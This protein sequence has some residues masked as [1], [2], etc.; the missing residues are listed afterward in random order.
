MA[1]HSPDAASRPPAVSLRG[2]AKRFGP[3]VAVDGV[4]LDVPAG[5][6]HAL[7]GENGAGKTSLMNVLAGLYRP[8]QGEILIHGRPV[9]IHSPDDARRLGIGMVH[10]EQRL[11]GRFSAPENVSLGHP[12]EPG[13]LA[14]GGYFR[15]LARR[16][17]RRYQLPIDAH[18]PVWDLPL[19]RRQRVELVKL[20]HHG[21]EI[22]ILDEPSGNLAP[23]EVEVFFDSVRQLVA[24]GRTVILITHKLEEVLRYADWVTVMR[25]G[26]VVANLPP[27]LVGRDELVRL[28]VGEE[29][30]ALVRAEAPPPPQTVGPARLEI[31]GLRAGDPRERGALVDV[32]LRVRGGEL[33]AIA[34]V[35]GNGQTRLAEAVTGEL[36]DY[37]GR[38]ALDGQDLRGL[39]ARQV[40]R[41]GVAYLPE[42]RQEVGL[43]PSASV[44]LN[45]VLRRYDQPPFS[46]G[47]WLDQRAIRAEADRLIER[48]AIRTPS[49]DTPVGQLSGGNQQRV[50][51]ARELSGQPRLIVADNV[52]RGLDPLSAQQLKGELLAHRARGAAA[53]WITGDLSEALECD[54]VAVLRGGRL[55][56]LLERGEASRES[57]GRLMTDQEAGER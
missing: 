48:Y 11:V 46:R 31:E 42:N 47:G 33:V 45:L 25:A 37:Q 15:S 54:R 8:D 39:D 53:L 36:A 12:R 6:V 34:G 5:E 27:A 28:M 17:S 40:A 20:L 50:I 1:R 55:V 9:E 52:T 18:A 35:A 32:N 49:P 57:V 44:A 14:T 13:F 3:V 16:L 10:Q 2:I 4:D 21:A 30:P 51:I 22:L 43:I 56:G 23:A 38:V 41:L 29:L 26:R 7:L 19:G 24:G